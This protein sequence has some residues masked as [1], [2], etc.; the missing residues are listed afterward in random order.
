[1]KKELPHFA[2]LIF[3]FLKKKKAFPIA[4]LQNLFDAN[5]FFYFA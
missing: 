2:L 5:F 1:M 4:F 3:F